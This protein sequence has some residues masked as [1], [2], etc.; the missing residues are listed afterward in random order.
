[1]AFKKGQVANPKGRPKGALHKTTTELKDMI[2]NALNKAGGEEYLLDQAR[3]NPG[4][5]MSL[6]G[7]ILPKDINA[8]VEGQVTINLVNEFE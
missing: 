6:V 4:P 1:M 5:F 8:K 3:N 7:K 2:L